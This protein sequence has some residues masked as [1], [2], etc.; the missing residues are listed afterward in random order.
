MSKQWRYILP[1]L[2][3]FALMLSA[4]GQPT[5][6]PAPTEEPTEEATVE[7]TEAAAEETEEAPAIAAAPEEGI[8]IGLVTDVGEVDDRSF[9]QSAWEGVQAAAEAL[10][11]TAQYIETQDS[12]D[13]A[14]NIAEFAENGYDII[15][16]VGFA[17][18]EATIQAAND[19]PDVHFIGIDQFQAE[20]LPNLTGLVFHEDQAG[21]LAG[22]LAGKLT[23]SGI[24]AGVYGTDTVPPVVAFGTGFENGARAANPDVQVI[25]TY[26]PGGI[27]VAFTDPEWGAATAAQ[28]VDQGA[29]IIFAAG[30][31][32]GNGGLGEVANRTTED[33]PL[34]CI[35]VDTD[36]WE[37]VPEA[38]PCL[39]TSAVKLIP[40]G[41]QEIIN[42]VA[43]GNPPAGN[44]YGPVGL[45]DFHDFADVVPADL[46]E[47]LATLAEQLTSGEVSTGYNPGGAAAEE[48][49]AEEATEEAT[50][51]SGG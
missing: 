39:I 35:G 26:H 37:T 30:G 3:V 10:G 38:H 9:N 1:L 13:Y 44:Y 6:T 23:R 36:Q 28:A 43:E 16:T 51:T 48:A 29:D 5:A 15:V 33:N 14:N 22:Y 20:A 31:K 47:E 19:Y 49:P 4:C 18:G 25:T 42:L 40:V 45:A 50:E 21:Y 34:Y 11:G 17:L 32:T 2:L 46:Q 24:V 41:L 8:A 7:E 12:T 27:D